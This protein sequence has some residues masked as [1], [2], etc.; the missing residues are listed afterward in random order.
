MVK[1]KRIIL[2]WLFSKDL[3]QNTDDYRMKKRQK[4]NK[5]PSTTAGVPL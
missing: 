2:S 5:V 1:G 4:K 3:E